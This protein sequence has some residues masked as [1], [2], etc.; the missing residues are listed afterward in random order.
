MGWLLLEVGKAVAWAGSQETS[1]LLRRLRAEEF[2]ERKLLSKHRGFCLCAWALPCMCITFHQ[3]PCTCA[4]AA[5][6]EQ[7]AQVPGNTE[8]S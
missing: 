2:W 8:N 3:R 4:E 5:W 1:S 7:G 6:R